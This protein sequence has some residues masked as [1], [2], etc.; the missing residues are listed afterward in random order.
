MKNAHDLYALNYAELY[1]IIRHSFVRTI[2]I[3]TVVLNNCTARTHLQT[4]LF[5]SADCHSESQN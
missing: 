2:V 5:T 4:H 1:D 3:I